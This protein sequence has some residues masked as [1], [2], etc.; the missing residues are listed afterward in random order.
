MNLSS[1]AVAKTTPTGES[2]PDTVAHLR[3][4]LD[5]F[6]HRHKNQHHSSHWWSHFSR[7]RRSLCSLLGKDGNPSSPH[8]RW[9]RSHVLPRSYKAFSQLA[10]D[11]QHAPL[12][13][14]LLTVLARVHALL[15]YI[16]PAEEQAPTLSSIQ[17]AL[18]RVAPEHGSK[19]DK[20]IAVARES[21]ENTRA[22]SLTASSK[23]LGK[24]SRPK[25]AAEEKKSS[26]KSKKKKKDELSSLFGS[27]T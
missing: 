13:L 4:L 22:E 23:S 24:P 3:A 25:S 7:L 26:K 15:T 6:N 17:Q 21:R 27:L 2:I 5:A 19:V 9:L 10:A 11:N 14:L 18:P 16:L 12:G 8:A 1:P 20:G